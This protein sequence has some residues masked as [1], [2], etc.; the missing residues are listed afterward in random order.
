[1]VGGF[2]TKRNMENVLACFGDIIGTTKDTDSDSGLFITDLEAVATIQGLISGQ[3][4]VSVE[5][6]EKLADA[7]RIAILRLHT[8]LS[9][10]MLR[11]AK[12]RDSMSVILGSKAFTAP[13]V[14]AGKSGIRIV[15]RA[16][17]D[18]EIVLRGI[19]T[20]FSQTGDIKAYI[21]SNYS[22]D[23]VELDLLTIANKVKENNLDEAIVL[24][25]WDVNAEG[26]VDYYIYHTNTIPPTN[27]KIQCSTCS[28]FR[29][30]ASRPSFAT[31]G[32]KQYINFAGFNGEIETLGSRGQ[33]FAK[34]LQLVVD[35]RC[36]TDKAICRDSINFHTNPMAMSFAT[37][38]QY[39]AASVVV[40]D[41][42]R[43]PGLNRILMG[44][45]ESFREAATYY[46]RKYN[47]MIKFI[48][49]NMPITSDCFCEQGFVNSK[50]GHP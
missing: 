49:K 46:N 45:I 18:A 38:I 16:I 14:E 32:H 39:Q 36:R 2:L 23:I 24:P 27:T 17:K 34:G 3:D 20:V 30:D 42:I 4:E 22:D 21:A 48:S 35:I 28:A 19:N 33:N 1:M 9:T 31:Y 5:I 41:L 26:C 43:S 37:A 15:C 44:D 25:L 7:K 40:W 50:I 13:L 6:E 11:Y 10:L 29:F 47:D 12:P 8:D